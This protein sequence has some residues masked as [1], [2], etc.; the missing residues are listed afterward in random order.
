[1]SAGLVALSLLQTEPL[2]P[3]V[4]ITDYGTI[5]KDFRATLSDD[6]SQLV[7]YFQV[8]DKVVKWHNGNR[9]ASEW[10]KPASSFS[11]S[12][13]RDSL[14]ISAQNSGEQVKAGN[15]GVAG[16]FVQDGQSG[17]F[18][19][20]HQNG[21]LNKKRFAWTY[22]S[23]FSRLWV[24]ENGAVAVFAYAEKEAWT[25]VVSTGNELKEFKGV[26]SNDVT[27][28]GLGDEEFI[29]Y[30]KDASGSRCI[31]GLSGVLRS[32]F[33]SLAFYPSRLA[34]VSRFGYALLQGGTLGDD[35]LF[36]VGRGKIKEVPFPANKHRVLFADIEQGLITVKDGFGSDLISTIDRFGQPLA[37]PP[38]TAGDLQVDSKGN[39]FT[40][41][42][43]T[44]KG[45]ATYVVTRNGKPFWSLPFPLDGADHDKARHDELVFTPDA[46]LAIGLFVTT[47]KD[48]ET[49]TYHF[50]A[51]GVTGGAVKSNGF[52][53]MYA[54]SKGKRYELDPIH[55]RSK[56]IT[57]FL[58]GHE[59]PSGQAPL[60]RVDVTW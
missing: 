5:P 33:D 26:G 40:Q 50:V 39:V 23:K 52:P 59:L 4:Q 48:R 16:F 30:T 13:L 25:L 36:L 24:S 34:D 1:M 10:P 54:S 22:S 9:S 42:T 20:L 27:I 19:H 47:S 37:I 56:Q 57:L 28:M 3:K 35:K 14:K 2:K 60:T 15:Q 8:G 29:G 55:L 11:E 12:A 18:G 46:G 43:I 7:G 6:F 58:K 51:N 32:G 44:E 17:W 41:S 31:I 53:W 21:K 38:S 49:R 45:R